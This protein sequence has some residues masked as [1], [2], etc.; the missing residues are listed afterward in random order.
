VTNRAVTISYGSDGSQLVDNST[1]D[2]GSGSDTT[3]AVQFWRDPL[4][5]S[6]SPVNGA[7]GP[8]PA[9]VEVTFDRTIQPGDSDFSNAIAVTLN[10]SPVSGATTPTSGNTTSL[11]WTPSAALSAG[12]Y[13]VTVGNVRSSLGGD[14]VPMQQPYI[15]SFTVP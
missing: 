10:G 7:S 1:T 5:L 2:W 4:V 9:N 8:A 3:K 12:S 14:S 11:T 15:F 13:T 6:T